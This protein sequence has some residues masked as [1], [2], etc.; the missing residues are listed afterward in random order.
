[1]F[2]WFLQHI[3]LT[4]KQYRLAFPAWSALAI[5]ER[6]MHGQC[7]ANIALERTLLMLFSGTLVATQQHMR[8]RDMGFVTAFQVE[9][10]TLSL[11]PCWKAWQQSSWFWQSWLK[12]FQ[13][14]NL[15]Y[16]HSSLHSTLLLFNHATRTQWVNESIEKRTRDQHSRN[17]IIIVII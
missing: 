9:R 7:W 13:C 3:Y 1:M 17:L 10:H 8:N 12:R 11:F 14:F 5:E 2:W 16:N 15:S 4:A 6:T